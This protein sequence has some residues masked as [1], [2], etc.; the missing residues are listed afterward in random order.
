MPTYEYE[1]N[2]CGER[3]DV[4][5]SFSEAPLTKHPGK[6]R[7]KVVK[8][9]SPAGIVFSGSG[10]YKTDNR[11]SS[12]NGASKPSTPESGSKS[13]S[14]SSKDSSTSSKD[15]GG[16]SKPATTTTSSTSSGNS[17]S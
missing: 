4:F 9:M 3:F 6:C 7:G 17:S 13:D 8:V 16:S 5:Q 11:S 15:S 1:C 10:F 12:K 2:K 14:G